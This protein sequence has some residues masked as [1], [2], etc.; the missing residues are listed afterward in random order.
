MSLMA[1]LVTSRTIMTV[2]LYAEARDP[3]SGSGAFECDLPGD[4]GHDDA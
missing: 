3:L 2:S 4:D 1:P